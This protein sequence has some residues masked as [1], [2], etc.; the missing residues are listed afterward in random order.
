MRDLRN[1]ATCTVAIG[2][3]AIGVAI[4]GPFGVGT[5]AAGLLSGVGIEI[6]GEVTNRR[7]EQTCQR[8]FD[9]KLRLDHDLQRAY[10][11]A[12]VTAAK[13][14]EQC[15]FTEEHLGQHQRR[16]HTDEPTKALFRE[17]QQNA[18][19]FLNT[20]WFTKLAHD[21]ET[22]RLAQT[23]GASAVEIFDDTLVK[24]LSREDP[25]FST[26]MRQ[27]FPGEIQ[28]CFEEELKRDDSKG[29]KA[30][31]AY[32]LLVFNQILS[33]QDA[34]LS[35]LRQRGGQDVSELIARWDE[36]TTRLQ[37][38]R[39]E[40]TIHISAEFEASRE[41]NREEHA[42]T[43]DAIG[44][45]RTDFKELE[46]AVKG[47]SPAPVP[48]HYSG[49]ASQR[50]FEIA[51]L[52]NPHLVGREE[53]LDTLKREL[54]PAKVHPRIAVLWGL[55]G[56]GKTQ[57]AAAYAFRLANDTDVVWW[58]QAQSE[59]TLT[60]DYVALARA[61]HLPE[62]E[63]QDQAE[64][65]KAVMRWLQQAGQS[66]LLIFDNAE[67]Q[68]TV[69]PF[70][71]RLGNG[72]VIITTT[73]PTWG[74][75][76]PLR[77]N[78]KELTTEEAAHFLELRSGSGHRKSA[79]QLA[80]ELAGLPLALAQAAAYMD[81]TG[82]SIDG[83]LKLFTEHR[84]RVLDAPGAPADHQ[85]T[86]T[87]TWEVALQR[88]RSE[89][90]AAIDLLTLCAFLAPERIPLDLIAAHRDDLPSQLQEALRDGFS[91]SMTIGALRA[92]SL[93]EV[94]DDSTINI[95]R[96]VQ[97]VV[98]DRVA[99]DLQRGWSMSAFRAV[100]AN[101]PDDPREP[102]AWETYERLVEHVH[103]SAEQ[104][105]WSHS[106]SREISLALCKT[107][108]YFQERALY[109]PARADLERAVKIMGANHDFDSLEM[110]TALNHFAAVS[111]AEGEVDEARSLLDRALSLVDEANGWDKQVA[112]TTLNNLGNILRAQG[113]LR[114]AEQLLTRAVAAYEQIY[115]EDHPN[116][117]TALTNVA[118]V[119]RVQDK[120]AEA[121]D[122]LERA[123]E[124][125]IAAFGHDH[126]EVA[127]DLSALGI[128]LGVQGELTEAK[129]LLSRALDLDT[130]LYGSD[131][132]KV[133][134]HLNGLASIA[135]A[136]GDWAGAVRLRTQALHIDEAVYGTHH[137][138]V[139]T[140]LHNLANVL[141]AQGNL[142]EATPL[143]ERV[144]EITELITEPG[145]FMRSI[146]RRSLAAVLRSQGDFANATF[147]EE[148]GCS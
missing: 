101:L 137:S 4:A 40:L 123:L 93:V 23:G 118:N 53:L 111:R 130:S 67:R 124:I 34:I 20:D 97:N 138:V 122:L 77:Y 22:L 50:V 139:V 107:G 143:R 59:A 78:I 113:D 5:V 147:L 14:L 13:R 64:V 136:E 12:F 134:I 117:A 115:G 28:R 45:L 79:E 8:V 87:A 36:L 27:R 7:W 148:Q 66:W 43:R 37:R 68:E 127:T 82:T 128:V 92:Y 38:A 73:S 145:H 129:R 74:A 35:E 41:R 26:Y 44:D 39:D 19:T 58:L 9:R 46:L 3:V 109:A 120:F 63:H 2:L 99:E 49:A 21:A 146:A 56:V 141:E 15:W 33:N 144:V 116:V 86:V 25:V 102:A 60:S 106:E 17:L 126:R 131:H 42:R 108:A 84:L 91:I 6:L 30:R 96:L 80:G 142:G 121:R 81:A 69:R 98:R 94:L 47:G 10:Q 76:T 61:L 65:T 54:S 24:L 83:Y 114:G 29:V 105:S 72:Q 31:T 62:A 32:E 104:L 110:A 90:P 125:D 112:V 89:M 133:A 100:S 132:P 16:T 119:M 88:V 135:G 70:I 95:H 11:D 71:P 1:P 57:L 18:K 103:A 85:L 51:H 140:D 52:P 48:S 55:G 75:L